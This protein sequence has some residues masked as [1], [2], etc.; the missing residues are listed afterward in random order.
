MQPASVHSESVV[1]SR[2]EDREIPLG[3]RFVQAGLLTES[4]LDLAL[5][6]QG[7][8]GGYLGEVLVQLGFV[9]TEAITEVLARENQ[10]DVYDVRNSIIDAKV[11]ELISYETA[12]RFKVIPVAF[13]NDG[14]TVAFA[15][16][17]DVVAMDQVERECGLFV[18]VVTAPESHIL[19][20]IERSYTRKKSINE[21]IE[22]VLSGRTVTAGDGEDETPMVRLVDQI[23]A[24]AIK[25]GASDIHFHAEEKVLR[26]RCRLDGVLRQEVIIPK[27]IQAALIGRIKLISGLN[28][29]EKRI[30]QDGRIR[31]EFGSSYVDLRVSTLPTNQGESVVM[32]VLDSGAVQFSLGQLG[33]SDIDR[34]RFEEA[35]SKS[36]GMV[37]V[38]GPTGSGKT[39]TLYTALSTIDRETRSVFTLE[40]PIEYSLPM[41]RQ[42]Q[43]NDKVGMNF[44]TGLR[45]LLRQDPDVILVG[46][47]RD[48]ETAELA[49]RAALTGHTV[50]S[51]LHTNSAIGAISRLIDMGVDRYLVPSALVGIIGQRLLRKLCLDCKIENPGISTIFNDGAYSH[52]IPENKS[53]W[54]SNGCDQCSG[55]G[56]KGRLA[57]Y[58]VLLIGEQF[59]DVVLN[60]GSE[61]ELGEVAVKSGMTTLIEDGIRKANLGLTSMA[62]VLRVLS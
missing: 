6:E 45:A 9:S 46:E 38:T 24:D 18:T 17:Y 40:D 28:I 11:L 32:R 43:I 3:Q 4:Q 2:A 36:F 35:V 22:T 12:K 29:T 39:T 20:T 31:F 51:T 44:S 58:E 52:I 50:F 27:T 56:Y 26:V 23:L 37:L 34:E 21:A 47:I 13:N 62:E 33:L 14:L 25:N 53:H 42:T 30:P 19:E 54:T 41:I 10:V 5:R 7:R 59:H 48:Q 16:S 15:D 1:S 61:A 60:G 55:T 57:V 49:T 8:V